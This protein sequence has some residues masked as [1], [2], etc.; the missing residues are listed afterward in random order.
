MAAVATIGEHL[1]STNAVTNILAQTIQT[2]I[3]R[4]KLLALRVLALHTKH[5]HLYTKA[6][7]SH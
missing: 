6:N 5:R 2:H 3:P 7:K 4:Y 1:L